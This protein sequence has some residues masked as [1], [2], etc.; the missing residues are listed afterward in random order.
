MSDT[1]AADRGTAAHQLLE[2]VA[3]R[4][5]LRGFVTLFWWWRHNEVTTNDILVAH[6]DL[7]F[8]FDHLKRD[9]FLKRTAPAPPEET[10]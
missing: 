10:K 8:D 4:E 7:M 5:A 6:D 9:E 2:C 1:P 3:E